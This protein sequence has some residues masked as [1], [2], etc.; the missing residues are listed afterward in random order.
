MKPDETDGIPSPADPARTL[1][2]NRLHNRVKT[3]RVTLSNGEM[4]VLTFEDEMKMQRFALR[5]P[6]L[7]EWI[8][9]E[10]LSVFRGTK[11]DRT[12]ISEIAFN[13][14]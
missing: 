7:T 2:S 6:A 5:R 3:L 4:Q 13:K 8:K 11:F 12:P 9:F 14:D 10:I 1:R